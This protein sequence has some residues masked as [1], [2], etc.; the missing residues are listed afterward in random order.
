MVLWFLFV[1][2][3]CRS[4]RQTRPVIGGLVGFFLEGGLHIDAAAA[5]RYRGFV[6]FVR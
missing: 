2:F 1:M 4:Q 5:A 6:G 3:V